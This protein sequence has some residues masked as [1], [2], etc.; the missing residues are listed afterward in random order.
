MRRS[1]EGDGGGA[2]EPRCPTLE[3]LICNV[4]DW[5]QMEYETEAQL[6]MLNAMLEAAYD[7]ELYEG[8]N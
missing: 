1:D 2:A 7:L 4:R 5:M 8:Q 3:A 6:A